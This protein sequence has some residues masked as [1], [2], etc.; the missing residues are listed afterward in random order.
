[1]TQVVVGLLDFDGPDVSQL[2]DGELDLRMFVI[3]G[4]AP[5]QVTRWSTVSPG[6]D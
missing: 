3:L 6:A 1:M 4:D 5:G 2:L